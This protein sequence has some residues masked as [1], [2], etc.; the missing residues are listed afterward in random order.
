MLQVC[1]RKTT[2]YIDTNLS[3]ASVIGTPA[4]TAPFLVIRMS[5][6]SRKLKLV[7]F[8]GRASKF[9]VFLISAHPKCNAARGM[10]AI[11]LIQTEGA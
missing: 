9:Y 4:S 3:G 1:T 6:K 11:I 2:R 7:H 5:E 8:N 10:R